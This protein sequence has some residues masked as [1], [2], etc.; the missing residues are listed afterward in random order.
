[1]INAEPTRVPQ[2]LAGM[3]ARVDTQGG[4]K[5]AARGAEVEEADLI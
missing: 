5:R 2:D 4:A 3:T 1:M